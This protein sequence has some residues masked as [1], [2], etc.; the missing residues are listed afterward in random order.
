MISLEGVKRFRALNTFLQTVPF[1]PDVMSN[2][3]V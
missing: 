2:Q 3:E 1:S